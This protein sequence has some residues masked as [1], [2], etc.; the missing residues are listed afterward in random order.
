MIFL[1]CYKKQIYVFCGEGTINIFQQ[2][3]AN[4]YQ[5]IANFETAPG[6]RTSLFVPELQAVLC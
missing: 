5:V 4:H 3:D 2:Q 1:R 6:A